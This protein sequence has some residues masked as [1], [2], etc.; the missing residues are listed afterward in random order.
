M[1]DVWNIPFLN[2]KAR[3]RT[4]YPTQKPVELLD[5]II[6]ISTDAGDLV[7]DPF[8]GSGTTLV[9]AKLLGRRFIGMH[10]N[11]DAIKLAQTRL[12]DPVKSESH[13]LKV[14]EAAY[15]TKTATELAI[16]NQFDCI[17]VQRNKGI[18]A[19]LKRHYANA[20]VAIKVQKDSESFPEA[21]SLLTKAAKKK[22]CVYSVL[23]TSEE[24]WEVNYIPENVVILRQHATAL[25]IELEKLER[26]RALGIPAE[27]Y[28]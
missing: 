4:A 16:L 17:I 26:K 12:D 7:L 11:P 1:S 14:G 9:S 2:P 15:R 10:I 25:E 21:L 5:R 23:I 18:D 28:L 6:K 20:P 19:I 24:D 8:C 13:L 27:N 3:E 22:R